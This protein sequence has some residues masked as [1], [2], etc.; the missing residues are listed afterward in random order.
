TPILISPHDPARVYV[1]SQRLWR[2]D[3]RGNSWQAVSEDLT[4]DENRYELPFIGRTW[5]VDALHD[6]GAMS[7]FATLTA[8]TESPVAEGVIYVGTD[9]GRIH[10]TADGGKSWSQA[11]DLPG[12][13]DTV[14]VN[15]MEASVHD[16]DTVY[17]V[18]DAHKFGDYSPYVYVSD[19]RGEGWESISGDLPEGVIAWSIQQD[20]ENENL[21]FLGAEDG[22]Y[23]TV[24]SGEHWHKIGG[25]P[26]IPFRDIKLQ[27]RDG[28]LV[29]A[30]FG[31]GVYVLDDYSALRA[32]GEDSPGETA[33]VFPVRDA[34]WYIPSVPGQAVGMP[35]FG[36]DSFRT[37]NP[38]FGAM[39][40]YYL[41]EQYQ[42]L[43]DVRT[44]NEK[45]L[46]K[47]GEDIPF[48]GWDELTEE[49]YE[50]SPRVLLLVSDSQ[51]RPVRW[52]QAANAKGS[53]RTTWDLRLP[54]PNAVNLE[55]PEFKPPWVTD[56]IGPLAAPGTY[57]AQL[58][59]VSKG[60]AQALGNAQS[61]VVKPVRDAANG[62][63]YA[64]VAAFQLETAELARRLAGAS[65]ELSRATTALTRMQAAAVRTPGVE[66]ALFVRLDEFGTSLQKLQARL[67]GDP[68]R[69]RLDESTPPSITRR[70]FGVAAGWNTTQPPTDT[71]RRDLELARS[72]FAAVNAD[73]NAL[74]AG[75]LAALE[76]ALAD[77]GAPSWR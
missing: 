53:H 30:T 1:G 33:T 13:D 14:F 28:D 73:L 32:L 39:I 20:H 9:D 24:D 25:A 44:E 52:L 2:S 38:A 56:P 27:R 31:R 76:K 45:A 16:A 61:F 19:D 62:V 43:K 71:Q 65:Q 15:D 58:Y 67:S 3:D 60:T 49:S 51:G 18:V 29:G 77:A 8:I 48:P 5:S 70:A 47:D 10:A 46:R 12:V 4:G 63:D 37:P 22:V 68:V 7:K 41:P 64:A 17:A 42:T 23:F 26:R 74:L 35:T 36:S 55:Q 57:S 66:P 72:E 6:N 34:W 75:E 40:T 21:L 54:A 59:A 69:A 50:A 11:D